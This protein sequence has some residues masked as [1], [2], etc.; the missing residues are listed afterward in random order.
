MKTQRSVFTKSVAILTTGAFFFAACSGE[1][2]LSGEAPEQFSVEISVRTPTDTGGFAL[3]SLGTNVLSVAD[4]E[5]MRR[6]LQIGGQLTN[7]PRALLEA[8]EIT[9]PLKSGGDMQLR[10]TGDLLE[11]VGLGEGAVSQAVTERT[12]GAIRL[13]ADGLD[14]FQDGATIDQEPAMR[15]DLRGL[16]G[17]EVMRQAF[18]SA[19][20]INILAAS[21]EDMEHFD[22]ATW[23]VIATVVAIL[24]AAWLAICGA[25]LNWC[26]NHCKN[27]NGFKMGC[28]GAKVIVKDDVQINFSGNIDCKCTN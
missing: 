2:P 24:G 11:L 25:T 6:P 12:A 3:R 13:T 16:E 7:D 8:T 23:A 9:V 20:A 1:T 15:L 5:G 4:Y 21:F 14:L 10:R 18:L 26:M 28:L 27:R 19:L 22:P 17:H